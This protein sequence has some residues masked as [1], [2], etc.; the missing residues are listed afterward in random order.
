[1]SHAFGIEGRPLPDLSTQTFQKEVLND[2]WYEDRVQE[3]E[4][5]PYAARQKIVREK[6]AD[7][8]I[9]TGYTT[10][11]GE[12]PLS[13]VPRIERHVLPDTSRT[14]PVDIP[15]EVP[16]KRA[17]GDKL[18]FTTTKQT[19]DRG[20][21]STPPPLDVAKPVPVTTHNLSSTLKADRT[22]RAPPTG[23]AATLPRHPDSEFQGHFETT[24][25]FFYDKKP[26]EATTRS[27][28]Y[29]APLDKTHN[30][31][32][33]LHKDTWEEEKHD[34]D[35]GGR[36]GNRGEMTRRPGES[37]N[38]YGVS[39]WVDEYSQWGEK[40]KGMSLT[41]TVQKKQTKYF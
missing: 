2:N 14:I 12:F 31:Q 15:G 5:I 24:N 41:E 36:S 20:M 21:L 25:Q 10:A 34:N 23:F 1:M 27:P 38:P 33:T 17:T 7:C 37:G 3:P 28:E 22:T 13:L 11:I 18:E 26:E 39:T 19:M 30:L 16:Y 40:L 32:K 8:S 6:E 9:V 4:E 35:V 29:F